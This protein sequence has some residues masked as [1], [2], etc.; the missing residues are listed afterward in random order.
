MVSRARSSIGTMAAAD[1]VERWREA[2]LEQVQQPTTAEDL[3]RAALAEDLS[4][5]TSSLTTAVVRSCEPLGWDAAAKWNPSGRLPE[6]RKEYLGIDVTALPLAED[7]GARWP[8]PVAVFE[9]ENHRKDMRVAYSLWKVLCIRA[10]L[11]V[12]IAY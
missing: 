11:R 4:S 1:L 8:L 9:L 2:F 3:K 10:A 5:W 6:K 12:V 7:S